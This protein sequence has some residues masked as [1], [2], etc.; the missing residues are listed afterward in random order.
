MKKLRTISKICIYEIRLHAASKRVL[1]GYLLG[2]AV[3][4]KQ[5]MGYLCYAGDCGEPIQVCEAFIAACNDSTALMF[6][7]LGWLLV[8]SDAP[9]L[10]S[11]S[12]YTLYR[13]EKKTWNSA[14][15]LYITLQGIMYYISMAF[16]SILLSAPNGY[17]ANIWSAPLRDLAVSENFIQKWNLIFPYREFTE[18]VTVWQAF[19]HTCLLAFCYGMVMALLLYICN[20]AF[21]NILG[22][23]V[24]IG[25]HF[26]GYEIYKE[27]FSTMIDFSLLARSIPA[28]QIGRGGTDLIQTYLL[29]II[30]FLV[31]TEVAQ[32]LIKRTDMKGIVQGGS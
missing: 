3:M 26:L 8:I 10:N 17:G 14:M 28:Y 6:L 31:L 25:F 19:G 4:I 1:M 13:T 24:T 32:Q 21:K 22:M 23:V 29:Y 18:Q 2:A 7:T 5:I 12:L 15:I 27:S 11:A 30:L 20:L 16:I 9:F